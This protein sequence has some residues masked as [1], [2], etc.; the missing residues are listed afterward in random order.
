MTIYGSANF[1]S[2]TWI[3]CKWRQ[4]STLKEKFKCHLQDQNLCQQSG[5]VNCLRPKTRTIPR[6]EFSALAG[7]R[8]KLAWF[9]AEP[10]TNYQVEENLLLACKNHASPDT[11]GI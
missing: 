1:L 8:A 2:P 4:D 7:R 6:L 10:K 5:M 9:F 3:P 11:D